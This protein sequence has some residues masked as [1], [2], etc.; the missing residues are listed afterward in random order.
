MSAL[1]YINN[2]IIPNKVVV[3]NTVIFETHFF[4]LSAYYVI[5]RFVISSQPVPMME[6]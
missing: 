1:G 3:I 4:I 5:I 6:M 2:T